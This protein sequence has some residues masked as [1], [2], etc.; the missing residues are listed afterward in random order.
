MVLWG[1][2]GCLDLRGFVNTPI[3]RQ[4][5][6]KGMISTS[7]I[8]SFQGSSDCSGPCS[9]FLNAVPSPLAIWWIHPMSLD[10]PKNFMTWG[11][12][13]STNSTIPADC[14][15]GCELD[16][17]IGLSPIFKWKVINTKVERIWWGLLHAFAMYGQDIFWF[18]FW[19]KKEHW[20][21]RDDP[22]G[23]SSKFRVTAAYKPSL[24]KVLTTDMRSWSEHRALASLKTRVKK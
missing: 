10:E 3:R 14:L 7:G 23:Q 12:P 4:R 20:L 6:E 16:C 9:R 11:P 24:Q 22:S 2:M 21:E 18:E 8:S 5:S 13:S 1:R 17:R 15:A 19:F